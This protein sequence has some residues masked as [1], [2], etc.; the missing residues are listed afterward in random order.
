[1]IFCVPLNKI[2]KLKD[3]A[4]SGK[5]DMQWLFDAG[6]KGRREFFEKHT[7]AE[8][9][10]FLNVEF[11]KAIASTKKNAFQQ[12]AESAFTPKAKAA[13]V[14]KTILD[15]INSLEEI[16]VLNP[17]S[18]KAFLADLVS[19][20][21]GINVSA[22]E[23][24]EISVRAEKIAEAQ[25]ALGNNLGDPKY[26]KE[27]L[28]FTKAK[29]EM[30]NYLLSK[31]PSNRLK[32][33]MGTIGRGNFLTSVAGPTLNLIGNTELLLSESISRRLASNAWKGTDNKLA[34][35]YVKQAREIFKETGYDITRMRKLEDTGASGGRIVDDIVHSQ[36]PGVVRKIGRVYEDFIFKKLYGRA[37][38]EFAAWHFTD[39]VNLNSLKAAKGD[40]VLAREMMVDSMRVD[41]QTTAGAILREQGILDAE[42]ATWTN[43]T[44]A[45]QITLG[46]RD[47]FNAVSGDF[48]LGDVVFPLVK[49]GS[50]VIATGMDYAGLGIPKALVKTY[51]AFKTGDLETMEY[52]QAAMRD[53]V[54][55]GLGVTA[56]V[57]LTSTLND[58]DFVGA[59]DPSRA[60]I[61][62]LRNSK[63]NSFRI[64]GKWYSVDLLGPIA[65]PFTAIMYARKYGKKGA[66][67][68]GY[69]YVRGVSDQVFNLPV[70]KDMADYI[71]SR[72]Y[73]KD[74]TLEEATG[75]SG[76]FL[77]E[78][79]TSRLVPNGMQHIGKTTDM[80]ERQA[81][82]GAEA[83]KAKVPLLREDL[84]E[85][86][87]IFG[88]KIETEKG[89]IPILFGSRVNTDK[90]NGM[91]REIRRVSDA[92]DKPINFTD[93]TK[94]SRKELVQF[95]STVRPIKFI[96]ARTFYGKTLK[97]NLNDIMTDSSY[98]SLPMEER[99]KLINQADEDAIDA[100][101]DEYNFNYQKP[102]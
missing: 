67:E 1:M 78:E 26:A 85:K 70:I 38:M 101:F 18:E 71:R 82:K 91:I 8:L 96:E 53:I 46:I 11:E 59:Y 48:R 52:R 56:A 45:S 22:A 35:D 64:G 20:K 12:W 4:L 58:D 24:R 95:K 33:M 41:P 27:A 69:Q 84:P 19:D 86:R 17:K 5:V 83:I 94:S 14:Y 93:W 3:A 99:Y 50:N 73:K 10:K 7:D 98:A 77:L 54:R 74:Q 49:T 76:V 90:E 100:T 97:Q 31:A 92:L 2:K 47:V 51:N 66:A 28:E 75:E 9:G 80:Y 60:Q 63:D 42:T 32:V 61:E 23:V 87:D 36:G 34:R 57:I 62:Q 81:N 88:K 40:R 102:Q 89:L 72:M 39:S 55:S 30:D 29:A 43:K 6:T 15:K 16:G 44:W 25:K 21:L 68:K 13:P 65:V 79:A 37:D